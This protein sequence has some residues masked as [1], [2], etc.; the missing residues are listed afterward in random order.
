MNPFSCRD[1]DDDDDDELCGVFTQS[2]AKL[3]A[4]GHAKCPLR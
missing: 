2:D 1:D 4:L 3:Y